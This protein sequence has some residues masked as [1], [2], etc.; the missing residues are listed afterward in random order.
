MYEGCGNRER[1]RGRQWLFEESFC[2]CSENTFEDLCPLY[3]SVFI[4][5]WWQEEPYD[6]GQNFIYPFHWTRRMMWLSPSL[7]RNS[8][9]NFMLNYRIMGFYNSYP[10]SPSKFLK[11]IIVE[12]FILTGLLNRCFA[13]CSKNGIICL[14][15]MMLNGGWWMER[16]I[17]KNL[18]QSISNTTFLISL[19]KI[20]L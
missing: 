5:L 4:R 7:S 14:R 3:F 13:I 9:L 17:Q 6:S 16:G 20:Q 2:V 11:I 12:V 19:H 10:F 8:W 18:H 15:T 1:E